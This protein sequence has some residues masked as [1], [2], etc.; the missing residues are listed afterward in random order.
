MRGILMNSDEAEKWLT[1]AKGWLD[2]AKM[3]KISENVQWEQ[4]CFLCQQAAE[5]S[6]KAL[7]ELNGI[8]F[9]KTHSLEKLIKN[10]EGK[11][12]KIPKECR[13]VTILYGRPFIPFQFPFKVGNARSL[14][15]NVNTRY[16]DTNY[17]PMDETGY[18][19]ALNLSNKI[20]TYVEEQIPK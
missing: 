4:L 3:G 5:N 12:F 13:N 2:L 19:N 14:T 1:N 17:E 18:Q 10:I 20:V 6:Y 11:G 8:E 16:P 7:C 9:T 15:A